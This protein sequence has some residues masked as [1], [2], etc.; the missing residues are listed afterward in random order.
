MANYE[1]QSPSFPPSGN[2][3]YGIEDG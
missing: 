2:Q 1:T 3:H